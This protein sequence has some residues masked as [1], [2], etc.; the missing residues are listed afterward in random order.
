LGHG[1][2]E[3]QCYVL[4]FVEVATD[5]GG[6]AVTRRSVALARGAGLSAREGAQQYIRNCRDLLEI[7]D[8]KRWHIESM[9]SAIR[10][11]PKIS[12]GS[13]RAAVRDSTSEPWNARSQE[14]QGIWAL[15]RATALQLESSDLRRS[16]QESTMRAIRAL[17]KG[18]RLET[19][20]RGGP[21]SIAGMNDAYEAA[22]ASVRPSLERYIIRYGRPL[23]PYVQEQYEQ[24]LHDA[25][26]TSA[27][28]VRRAAARRR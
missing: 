22:V 4:D 2:G 1:P 17:V 8:A 15:T 11:N 9:M 5:A 3:A 10:V 28:I 13:I 27:A 7:S 6:W 18:G 16:Q 14:L 23:P 21:V 24:Q 26:R 25:F 20:G 12:A 19:D